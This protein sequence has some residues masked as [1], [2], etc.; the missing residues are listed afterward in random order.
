[1]IVV[2]VQI[3][4]LGQWRIMWDIQIVPYT[5]TDL[6]RQEGGRLMARRLDSTGTRG[7]S[8]KSSDGRAAAR[9]IR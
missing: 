5:R 8:K 2:A 6:R 1:M 3:Q 7:L 9:F 4:V